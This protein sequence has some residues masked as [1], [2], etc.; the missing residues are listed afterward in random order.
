MLVVNFLPPRRL[1]ESISQSRW[2][3]RKKEIHNE[4]HMALHYITVIIPL[5]PMKLRNVIDKRMPRYT[6]PKDVSF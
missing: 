1:R 3:T 4:L 5:A 6:D 2:L